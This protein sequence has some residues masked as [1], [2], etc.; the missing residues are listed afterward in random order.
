[1]LIVG[2]SSLAFTQ[3]I[4]RLLKSFTDKIFELSLSRSGK[5]F[6]SSLTIWIE[7]ED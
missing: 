4:T 3:Q 7:K 6:G 5:K 2:L 1:M